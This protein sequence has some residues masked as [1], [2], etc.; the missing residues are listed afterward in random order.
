MVRYP[1]AKHLSD[2]GS[3]NSMAAITYLG[4]QIQN[5]ATDLKLRAIVFYLLGQGAR[6][7]GFSQTITPLAPNG[8]LY[9]LVKDALGQ[10]IQNARKHLII[11]LDGWDWNQLTNVHKYVLKH[12]QGDVATT[13]ILNAPNAVNGLGNNSKIHIVGHGGPNRFAHSSPTAVADIIHNNLQPHLTVKIRIDTPSSALADLNGDTA[14]QTLRNR[15]VTHHNRNGEQISVS[16]T[17]GPSVTGIGGKRIVVIPNQL[18][19]VETLQTALRY[20]YRDGIQEATL[21]ANNLPDSPSNAQIKQA[22]RDVW[23]HTQGFFN[24]FEHLLNNWATLSGSNALVI[25]H[26]H[27][28]HK[29]TY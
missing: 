25:D 7:L 24:D 29:I 26:R 2:V 1:I 14:A 18:A 19:T 11:L 12:G 10:P 21:V 5:N 22:A 20:I 4:N 6:P 15:L 17:T 23:G 8:R 16:G 27:G 13:C 3:N 9:N 28:D